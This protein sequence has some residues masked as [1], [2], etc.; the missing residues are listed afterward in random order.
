MTVPAS[1][2]VVMDEWGW[3]CLPGIS[4]GMLAIITAEACYLGDSLDNVDP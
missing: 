4:T 3:G 2:V 1:W